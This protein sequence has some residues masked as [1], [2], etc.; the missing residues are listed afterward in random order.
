MEK[1]SKEGSICSKFIN[2]IIT[3]LKD[4]IVWNKIKEVFSYLDIFI[5]SDDF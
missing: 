3:L 2:I 4:V 1:F 5:S